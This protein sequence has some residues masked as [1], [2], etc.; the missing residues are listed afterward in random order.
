[1]E[2]AALPSCMKAYF[3]FL[4]HHGLF[5]L[6]LQT[7][8]VNRSVISSKAFA[9][10][11]LMIHWIHAGN[12]PPPNAF[13]ILNCFTTPPPHPRHSFRIPVQARNPPLPRNSKMPP[14][15][16][17]GYFLESPNA[18][19]SWLYANEYR[20]QWVKKETELKFCSFLHEMGTTIFNSFLN[21]ERQNCWSYH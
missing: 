12:P 8:K 14:M 20:G 7:G 5:V 19:P 10:F 3:C 4:L 6:D 9:I 11:P 1:M 16:W 13:G 15:V 18:H 2:L 21:W 17:H